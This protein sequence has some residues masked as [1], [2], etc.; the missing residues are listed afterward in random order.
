MPICKVIY[1]I[2]M[3]PSKKVN[4]IEKRNQQENCNQERNVRN[5]LILAVLFRRKLNFR[6][7][8][9]WGN[10]MQRIQMM[11]EQ[12]D[13]LKASL[14]ISYDLVTDSYHKFTKNKV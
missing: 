13:Q 12:N 7:Q 2:C 1:N 14:L 5:S 6:L 10:Y 3:S 9:K 11:L 4:K 8:A